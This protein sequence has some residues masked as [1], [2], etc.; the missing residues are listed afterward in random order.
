MQDRDPVTLWRNLLMYEDSKDLADLA[1]VLL[2]ITPNTASCER[3]FSDLGNKK[4]K[5]RN[6]MGLKR[7]ERLAKVRSAYKRL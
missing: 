5:K 4:T 1:I 7:L 3:I 6:R 2:T